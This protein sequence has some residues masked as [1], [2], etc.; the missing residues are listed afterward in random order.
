M[1]ERERIEIAR[2]LGRMT[3]E[4]YQTALAKLREEEER[5]RAVL[6]TRLARMLERAKELSTRD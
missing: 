5:E 2:L 3:E 6:Q 1:T 4:E